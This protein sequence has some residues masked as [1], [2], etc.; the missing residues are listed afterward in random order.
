VDDQGRKGG[1]AVRSAFVVMGDL[2]AD[3]F[4]DPPTY[5]RTAIAQLLEHPAV[6]DPKPLGESEWPLPPDRTRYPGDPRSRTSRFG[7]LDYVL[8]SRDL[9][10]SGSGVWYPRSDVPLGGLVRSPDPASDHALVWV[11]LNLRAR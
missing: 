6:Q 9:D 7:R 3:L 1:L 4:W 8:P 10:I 5:G 2:N 11:D